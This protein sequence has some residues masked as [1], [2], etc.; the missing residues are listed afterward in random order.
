[1][2]KTTLCCLLVIILATLGYIIS[3]AIISRNQWTLQRIELQ[4]TNPWNHTLRHLT[5]AEIH[6]LEIDMLEEQKELEFSTGLSFWILV[7]GIIGAITL[8]LKKQNDNRY[9]GFWIMAAQLLLVVATILLFQYFSGHFTDGSNAI[10]YPSIYT[11]SIIL[12]AAPFLSLLAYKI[13]NKEIDQ[14]KHRAKWCSYLS[15]AVCI[16]TSLC[17]LILLFGLLLTPDLS[18]NIT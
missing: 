2:T 7:C 3:N 18:G 16:V 4:K 17:L 5:P 14:G 6:D 1:M 8:L 13:N 10:I 9:I 11:Y 12:A 15:L